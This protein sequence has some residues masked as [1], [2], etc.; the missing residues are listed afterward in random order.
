MTLLGGD[1]GTYG[2]LR[3]GKLRDLEY[4][5]TFMIAYG[6]NNHKSEKIQFLC[7]IDIKKL[8]FYI[9]KE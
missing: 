2:M 8:N 1:R 3:E 6:I 5:V 7:I 9:A 4:L